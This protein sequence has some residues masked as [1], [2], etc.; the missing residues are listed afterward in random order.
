MQTRTPVAGS[1]SSY[2]ACLVSL[3][4]AVGL[5]CGCTNLKEYLSNGFKVGPNYGRPP[6]QVAPHWID[7]GDKRVRQESGDLS[8]WWV[9]F[10]DPVLNDLIC[11]AY[12][13]NLT[14]RE[15]GFRVLQ[16]RAQ[17]GI[18]VGT[19]F[20]QTQNMT[21]D[22]QHIAF[23]TQKA[24]TRFTGLQLNQFF[25]QWD[26]G[27]NIGWELD[28]WGR[29]RR[30]IEAGCAS[31]DASIEDY[32]DVL[33]TLLGDVASNYVQLRTTQKRIEYARANVA[34]QRDTVRIAE[35]RYKAGTAG[36]LDVRQ[37]KSILAQTE[38]QIPELQISA[39]QSANQLCILLGIPPIDLEAKIGAAPIP[40]APT[41]V[42]AGIPADLLRRRP[43]VR[44]AERQAA[45][46]SAQIGVAVAEF[47][48]HIS[49]N[50]AIGQSSEY[51]T[52]FFVPTAL[53]A[54]I[55]PGFQWNILQYGRIANGVALQKARF[56]E[57]VLAYQQAVLN[58]SREV[59]N[60]LVTFLRAQER[61]QFQTE[62]VD[63]ALEAVKLVGN[64]Y[65]VGTVDFTRV[66]QV[67]QS[68]VQQQDTLAQAQGEIGQGLIQV[69]RAL[70]G[71]WEI[72]CTGCV[73]TGLRPQSEQGASPETLPAP[74]PEAEAEPEK[75]KP[76]DEKAPSNRGTTIP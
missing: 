24:N 70:G 69:Y 73:T 66:T 61:T 76:K 3:L 62:S 67:Q 39:R 60:G 41:E 17:L 38:A 58:A 54:S 56:Q 51:F 25:S 57:L 37:S 22:Y 47:Y 49:I 75:T 74:R 63:E 7:A 10:N 27:F 72:R 64:Q 45:S 59:E 21:G 8:K 68:L 2:R 31:L 55:I 36:I 65:K 4:V 29:F 48:P 9:V 28:F 14:L 71:G 20:P 12:Q 34:I 11:C 30:A 40:T 32:D 44:R 52:H 18:A 19:F 33:V 5:G 35:A 50:G 13:Q 53:Q 26:Y 16:A 6:A 1:G 15:A 43:D 46:Q 23:S 42:A